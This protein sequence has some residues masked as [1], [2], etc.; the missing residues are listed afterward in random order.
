[1]NTNKLHSSVQTAVSPGKLNKK[2][3]MQSFSGY[4]GEGENNPGA[5]NLSNLL[6]KKKEEEK[7][8][9]QKTCSHLWLWQEPI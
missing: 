2:D 7:K 1:M 8:Q 3:E 4:A 6:Q 9:Q 5:I